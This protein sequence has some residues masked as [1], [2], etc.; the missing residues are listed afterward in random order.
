VLDRAP[1]A[2]PHLARRGREVYFL[3]SRRPCLELDDQGVALFD[4]LDGTRTLAEIAAHDARA[5]D[6]VAEWRA[7][8][9]VVALPRIAAPPPG[10]PHVVVIEPHMDDAALSVGGVLAKKRGHARITLVSVVRDSSFTSYAM[11]DRLDFA[12]VAAVTALRTAETALAARMLGAETHVVGEVDALLRFVRARGHER[13]PLS[14]LDAAV[15]AWMRFGPTDEEVEELATALGAMVRAL[16]PD[17]LWVPLGAGGHV[18]HVRTREACLSLVARG[19]GLAPRTFFYEDLPHVGRYPDQP[20][21]IARAVEA[22]DGELRRT[23]EDVG[24]V[25]D[26]KLE[27]VSAYASQFKMRFMKPLLVEHAEAAAGKAGARAEVFHEL[28]RAPRTVPPRRATTT[29][30]AR[31]GEV[32]EALARWCRSPDDVRRLA[33]VAAS[34]LGDRARLVATLSARFPRAAIEVLGDRDAGD[35]DLPALARA[36]SSAEAAGAHVLWVGD[37]AAPDA[38]RIA[39]KAAADVVLAL[40]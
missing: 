24:D 34:P 27:I 30:P 14:R 10:G 17:E 4:A 22:C 36:A 2:L 39:V 33:V 9:L 26:D 11:Q 40:A 32:G 8:G 1:R 3:A 25:F 18:D 5:I 31:A 21:H 37:G 35:A 15:R 7:R 20:E 29:Q 19:D 23:V 12:D 6:R 16:A 38:R 13:T 28:V